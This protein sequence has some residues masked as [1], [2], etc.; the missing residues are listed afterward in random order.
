MRRLRIIYRMMFLGLMLPV[1]WNLYGQQ[2]LPAG[3]SEPKLAGEWY[4]PEVGYYGN[5][6]FRKKWYKGEVFLWNGRTAHD[7]KLAYNVVQDALI[8]LDDA[9]GKVI[10][11][12][13]GLI[14]GFVLRDEAGKEMLF[15]NIRIRP[16]F[17]RDTAQVFVQVLFEGKRLAIYA[18]RKIEDYYNK[19]YGGTVSDAAGTTFEP[20]PEYYLFDQ[21]VQVAKMTKISRKNLLRVFPQEKKQIKRILRKHHV[22]VRDEPMLIKAVELIDPILSDTVPDPQR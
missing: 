20:R 9:G 4:I 12:D 11:L 2:M 14:T 6:L 21:G 3:L 19:R 16:L 22:A 13:K 5:Q 7:K 1:A 18:Q 8:W 10:R 17:S 15:K